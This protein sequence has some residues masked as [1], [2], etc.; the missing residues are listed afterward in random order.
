MADET[1]PGEYQPS[2]DAVYGVVLPFTVVTSKGGPYDDLAFTAGW[3]CGLIDG[4]LA[5]HKV[6]EQWMPVAVSLR[7]QVDLIAMYRGYVALWHDHPENPEWASVRFAQGASVMPDGVPES[8][9]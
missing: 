5:A 6:P 7:A 2:S 1:D 9:Q 8:W 3:Q 4:L